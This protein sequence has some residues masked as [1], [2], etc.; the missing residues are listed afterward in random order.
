MNLLLPGNT[1]AKAETTSRMPRGTEYLLLSASLLQHCYLGSSS[2][3][4]FCFVSLF[5]LSIF[6]S[7]KMEAGRV[8]KKHNGG[9][10][11]SVLKTC[12]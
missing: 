12:P 7:T 4:F 2:G 9:A 5:S 11:A 3:L 10:K 6:P 8:F 1:A